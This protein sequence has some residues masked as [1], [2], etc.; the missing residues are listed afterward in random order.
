MKDNSSNKKAVSNNHLN[1]IHRAISNV[2]WGSLE[3]FIQDSKIVQIT[4]R[5]I[6]KI[7]DK[8]QISKK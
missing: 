6:R 1:E 7:N 5:N 2:S 4:E 8:F 3:I